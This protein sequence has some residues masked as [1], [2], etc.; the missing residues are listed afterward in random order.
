MVKQHVGLVQ[1]AGRKMLVEE[2][3]AEF[4]RIVLPV[5]GELRK[6]KPNESL[7]VGT[8]SQNVLP[9]GNFN[10]PPKKRTVV[11]D[12]LLVSF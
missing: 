10:T 7:A 2:V 5:R 1:D 6:G 11:M 12:N 3:I 8:P 4:E 9:I